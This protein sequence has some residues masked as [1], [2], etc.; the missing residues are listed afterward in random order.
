LQEK[1]NVGSHE[2]FKAGSALAGGVA[3]RGETCGALTGAIMAIGCL[4]GRGRMEDLR[5]Y[6][7][8]MVVADQVYERFRQEIGHTLCWEIHKIRYGEVYR[9]YV[10]EEREAFHEM[11]GHGEKGCPEVCGVAARIAADVILDLEEKPS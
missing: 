3:R 10:K 9:L 8:A 2:V 7:R 5:Q 1:L 6:G 11:G 4:V